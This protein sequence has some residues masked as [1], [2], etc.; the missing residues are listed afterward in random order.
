M[1]RHIT[2]IVVIIFSV[3]FGGGAV[4]LAHCGFLLTQITTIASTVATIILAG[5]AVIG[6]SAWK[7][8]HRRKTDSDLATQLR[9]LIYRYRD[10]MIVFINIPAKM[11]RD[12]YRDEQRENRRNISSLAKKIN[13][14][15]SISAISCSEELRK[16]FGEMREIENNVKKTDKKVEENL[17]TI[18]FTSEN[19]Y[20]RKGAEQAIKSI[21][22]DRKKLSKQ[23]S[24]LIK[25]ADKILERE[26]L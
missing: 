7:V 3:T 10:A 18:G 15:I 6:L 20:A 9:T 13:S 1:V 12:L 25:K 26:I 17:G 14:N 19:D 4:I 24:E 8:Q 2:A 5:C 23:F 11:T 16:L 22:K 21:K